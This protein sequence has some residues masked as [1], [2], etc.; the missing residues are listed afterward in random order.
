MELHWH[1]LLIYFNY[2]RGLSNKQNIPCNDL[3][4]NHPWHYENLPNNKGF[5]RIRD[6]NNQIWN[7]YVMIDKH[8]PSKLGVGLVRGN[9]LC[10]F[11][12]MQTLA[13]I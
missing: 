10:W 3:N 8:K 7:P 5:K 6:C 1:L 2:I 12:I 13:I 9:I 11:H 4:C